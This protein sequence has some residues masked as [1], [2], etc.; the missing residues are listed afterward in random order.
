MLLSI[1][2]P[3]YNGGHTLRCAVDSVLAQTDPNWELI[4]VDDGSSDDSLQLAVEYG[5]KDDRI[6]VVEGRTNAGPAVARNRGIDL[7][8]GDW[9]GFLDCDDVLHRDFV[10]RMTAAARTFDADIV[11]CQY[12][13]CNGGGRIPVSS[14]MADGTLL[15]P[16]QALKLFYK[17]TDGIGSMWNKIYARSIFSQPDKLRINPARVRAEDWE[18]NIFAFR[19]MRRLAV[20]EESLYDYRHCNK[21]SVMSLFRKGDYELMWRS[22]SLLES[23]SRDMNLGFGF[24]DIVDVHGASFMEYAYRGIKELP[25]REIMDIFREERFMRCVD[26]LDAGRLP[27]TYRVLACLLKHRLYRTA[28]L[29]FGRNCRR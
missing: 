25:R 11:W 27:K 3:V 18:F 4:I 2:L 22:V 24:A 10:G 9:L 19:R 16:Q 28:C 26:S 6:R 14:G 7:A 23:V 1:I 29:L 20:L 17:D 5:R 13:I 8:K 15:G 12:E 21:E